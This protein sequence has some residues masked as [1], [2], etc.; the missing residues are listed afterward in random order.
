MESVFVLLI[1]APLFLGGGGGTGGDSCIFFLLY[2]GNCVYI[3]VIM[4]RTSVCL[5]IKWDCIG[6]SYFDLENKK[7][8][9]YAL[10]SL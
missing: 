10:A 1:L 5:Y 8:G 9:Y 4:N 2:G 3:P 7:K 6:L